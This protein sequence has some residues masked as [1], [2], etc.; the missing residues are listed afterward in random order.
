M[1]YTTKIRKTLCSILVLVCSFA[2]LCQNACAISQYSGAVTEN[3]MLHSFS[4]F[5]SKLAA[6]TKCSADGIDADLSRF[7]QRM[8]SKDRSEVKECLRLIE[9]ALHSY[10]ERGDEDGVMLCLHLVRELADQTRVNQGNHNTCAIAALETKLYTMNPSAVCRLVIQAKT[11]SIHSADGI[12]T[13]IPAKCIAPDRE[14]QLFTPDSIYRSYSSQLFQI[15]VANVYWQ[16]QVVDPRGIKVPLGSIRFVQE[17]G[18]GIF[19][20]DTRER[21]II[22]WAE[23][24]REF[25]AG[26]NNMPESGPAF[27]MHCI[28]RAYELVTGQKCETFILSHRSFGQN[29]NAMIFSDVNDL[30]KKLAE[31]KNAGKLPAIIAISPQGS[32][33]QTIPKLVLLRES[34]APAP[35]KNT[36]AWHVVCIHDFHAETGEVNIDNFW[37]PGS[38][39]LNDRSLTIAQLYGSTCFKK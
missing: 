30:S 15:A 4:N 34:G 29:K 8:V 7:D 3:V 31:L 25:V 1:Q 11:G 22:N 16:R 10:V 36:G 19:S 9:G 14:A 5:S 27:T 24:I 39:Y 18:A 37:G 13:V 23:G 33:I 6:Q 35:P 32:F 26:A 20:G 38:D 28:N 2:I 21:L 12:V 17:D